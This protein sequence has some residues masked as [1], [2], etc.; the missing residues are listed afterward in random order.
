MRRRSRSAWMTRARAGAL[1]RPIAR[2]DDAGEGQPRDRRPH[3]N[4]VP[5]RRR[6]IGAQVAARRLRRGN[7]CARPV[8]CCSAKPT[9][10]EWANIRGLQFDQRLERARRPDA[11]PVCARPQPRAVRHPAPA[12]AVAANLCAAGGRHR[13]RR[14]DHL[15]RRR[16]RALVGIKP[17]VGLL[18]R[19]GIV[20]ISFTQDTPGPMC[21]RRA[22][23]PRCCCR[24]WPAATP[25]ERRQLARASKRLAA[26][27]LASGSTAQSLRGRALGHREQ[28]RRGTQRDVLEALRSKRRRC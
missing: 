26:M 18:S 3:A 28:P 15:G 12:A 11:E 8:P 21:R 9:C 7:S 4:E 2:R 1:A 22:A 17:T 6:W 25:R 20:P 27:P 13:D 5:A 23:T 19:D 10:R 16:S 24:R 14:L